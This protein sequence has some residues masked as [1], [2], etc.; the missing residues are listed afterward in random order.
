MGKYYAIASGESA[1]AA[2]AIE[3]HYYP[4]FSGDELF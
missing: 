4:R 3:K 1:E 2:N